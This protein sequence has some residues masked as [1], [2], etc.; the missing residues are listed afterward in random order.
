VARR[1]QGA[2]LLATKF[3]LVTIAQL[4]R[5][6]GDAATVRR[7]G[8]RTSVLSQ[9]TGAGD[10]IGV[11]MGLH[12]P[13]QIETVLAQG[14]Q[15]AF[16]LVIDGIDDQRI[17]GAFIKQHIGI[18]AGGGVE[19]LDGVHGAKGIQANLVSISA[20]CSADWS[21]CSIMQPT[22]EKKDLSSALRAAAICWA[23]FSQS[24]SPSISFCNPRSCPSI[25]ASRA[26]KARFLSASTILLMVLG[27]GWFVV[28]FQVG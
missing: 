3:K 20:T 4:H 16:D 25:R 2:D 13:Q 19:Q 18:G 7:G 27:R 24:A 6:R 14:G 10:V 5:C 1:E 23:I 28:C 15:V 22:M 8:S 12:G 17:A 21:P 11:R 26:H 9:Q